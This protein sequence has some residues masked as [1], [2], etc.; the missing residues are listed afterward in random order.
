MASR[1]RGAG[2]TVVSYEFLQRVAQAYTA[3]VAQGERAPAPRLAEQSGATVHAVRKW[4]FTARKRG[5]MPPGRR[6]KAG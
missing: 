2:L 4:I 5:I 6:G 1:F 3:L